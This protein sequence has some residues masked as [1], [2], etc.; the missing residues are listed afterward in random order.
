MLAL[1]AGEYYIR[2]LPVLPWTFI[3]PI[4][5]HYISLGLPSA[6]SL[7]AN[8]K[9]RFRFEAM[10]TRDRKCEDIIYEGWK[11]SNLSLHIPARINGCSNSL[12]K[13]A[14][15][16]FH[17][18]SRELKEQTR[19]TCWALMSSVSMKLMKLVSLRG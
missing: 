13:W 16:R 9:R 15:S 7:S 14:A 8:K 18:F 4:I 5:D 2:Q 3:F 19:Q 17:L 12:Q 10:W 6:G 1:L 11:G